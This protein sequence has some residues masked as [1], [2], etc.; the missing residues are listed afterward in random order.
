MIDAL[1]RV[2]IRYDYDMLGAHLH[3]TIWMRASA[4]CSTTRLEN[5]SVAGTAGCTPFARNTIALRR[6]IRSFVQGGDPYERDARTYLREILFERTIYGDSTDTGLTGHRQREANLRGKSYR[7]F[8]TAGVVTSDR[9]D[10]K[11]NLL[12]SYRQFAKDY[13]RVPDWSQEQA[14]DAE[15]FVHRTNYDALN[16]VV[17][18]TNPDQSVY[19][20]T[21]NKTNL[22]ERIDVILRG[23]ERD[24]HPVW[25][26]FVSDIDYNAR[27]QRV[28]IDYANRVTTTY[29][30]DEKTFR[31]DRA[32]HKALAG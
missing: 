3:Q 23:A 5:Q 4:G 26:P 12:H 30:Y 19:R 9:Y 6:P 22:L 28:R 20:P 10:F 17:T 8:D 25:T 14:L 1:E 2:V 32:A 21:Y 11:G 29:R 16:R 24:G 7:H 27:A 15:T 18:V 13:K 31:L